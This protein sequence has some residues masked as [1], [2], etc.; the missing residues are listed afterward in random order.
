M[1]KKSIKTKE[2]KEEIQLGLFF[3]GIG[4]AIYKARKKMN[5]RQDELAQKTSTTQR[6]ISQIENADNYN[7]GAKMLFKL[8]KFLKI[9]MII[10]GYDVITGQ[11][12]QVGNRQI[13]DKDVSLSNNTAFTVKVEDLSSDNL[14]RC[15]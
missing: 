3:M 9:Q 12:I 4:D 15:L 10:D 14:C 7:M 2:F 6:I 5:L 11:E 1:K 13:L 8:F